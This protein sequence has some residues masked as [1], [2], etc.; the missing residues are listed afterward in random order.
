[1]NTNQQAVSP[2]QDLIARKEAEN[3]L[4]QLRSKAEISYLKY[5]DEKQKMEGTAVPEE[6]AA[7]LT[8]EDLA[9]NYGDRNI[10]VYDDAGSYLQTPG[11]VYNEDAPQAIYPDAY[12][13]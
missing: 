5:L 8:M 2:F 3:R 12:T 4:E 10:G 7:P 1:M 6:E 9:R 11:Q 13:Y